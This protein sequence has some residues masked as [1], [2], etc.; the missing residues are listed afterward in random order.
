MG[1][2]VLLHLFLEFAMFFTNLEFCPVSQAELR[3]IFSWS[4][5]P[6]T[7]PWCVLDLAFLSS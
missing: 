5:M 6:F 3:P 4:L 2:F 1:L 7:C